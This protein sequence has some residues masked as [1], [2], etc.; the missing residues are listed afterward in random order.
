[1]FRILFQL[2]IFTL[3]CSVSAQ[4]RPIRII[5]QDIPNRI[6]LYAVNENEHDLDVKLTVSGT[7]F[8]QSRSKPRFIRVPAT[9]KVHVKTLVLMRDKKPKYSF[10]IEV[11]D[12]L[13]NRALKKEYELIRIKPSKPVVIYL[14]PNCEKCDS[15]MLDLNNGRYIFDTLNLAEK[16]Q[17]K[18]QLQIAFGEAEPIDSLRTPVINIGGKLYTRIEKYEEILELLRK[19]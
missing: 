13:S 19:E 12:S 4:Q 11:N 2:C 14:T 7:N 10:K 9:S 6:A 3:F 8:R 15:L 16:P 5:E 17:I 18:D 1:M